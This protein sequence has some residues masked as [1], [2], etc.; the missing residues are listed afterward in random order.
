MKAGNNGDTASKHTPF[1]RRPIDAVGA[2]S[3]PAK[4]LDEILD[5]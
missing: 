2:P 1:K 5:A 4:A 3:L